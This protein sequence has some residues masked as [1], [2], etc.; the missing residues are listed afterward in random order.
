MVLECTYLRLCRGLLLGDLPDHRNIVLAV[1][2]KFC[3]G[4]WQSNSLLR[5]SFRVVANLGVL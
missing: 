2:R 5:V 4:W 3:Q 1:L